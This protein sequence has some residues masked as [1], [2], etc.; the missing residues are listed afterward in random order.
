[1]LF[2]VRISPAGTWPGLGGRSDEHGP[3]GGSGAAILQKRIGDGGRATGALHAERQVLVQIR[4]GGRV[5]GAHQRPV[6]I[7]LVGNERGE[8]RRVALTHLV[9]L[10]DHG[11]EIVGAH[12][13]ERVGR[14][15]ARRGSL[16]AGQ[17]GV[18][19]HGREPAETDCES[20][21]AGALEEYAARHQRRDGFLDAMEFHEPASFSS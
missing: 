20:G 7:E 5:L 14:K 19:V 1:M 10:A 12:A 9:V 21:R 3:R 11:D 8:A 2:D 17:S 18:G 6:G 4:I 16:Y 15:R 13:D